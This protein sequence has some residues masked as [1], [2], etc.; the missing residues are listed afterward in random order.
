MLKP[1]FQKLPVWIN[2][3]KITRAYFEKI[4]IHRF[5]FCPKGLTNETQYSSKT[6]EFIQVW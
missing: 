4:A 5:S 3:H 1:K 6:L 2:F